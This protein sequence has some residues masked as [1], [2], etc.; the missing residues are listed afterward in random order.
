MVLHLLFW[1]FTGETWNKS[2]MFTQVWFKTNKRSSGWRKYIEYLF[3]WNE[4][5]NKQH[6]CC[7]RQEMVTN[8]LCGIFFFIIIKPLNIVGPKADKIY[9]GLI[10]Y[11][12]N[13]MFRFLKMLV[14]VAEEDHVNKI[15]R[16]LNGC[17]YILRCLKALTI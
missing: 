12:Y 6:S 17:G 15:S 13:K 14:I 9:I 7:C 5:E 4:H 8:Y 16:M 3:S 11:N 2:I 1:S 10:S